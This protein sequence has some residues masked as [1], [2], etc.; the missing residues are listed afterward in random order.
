VSG[1]N[2]GR[3]APAFYT[4]SEGEAIMLR[5]QSK[6]NAGMTRLHKATIDPSRQS[7]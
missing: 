1:K 3:K 4:A 6:S 2:F 5:G 7:I